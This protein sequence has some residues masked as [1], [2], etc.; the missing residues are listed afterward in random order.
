M[1][2]LFLLS[3]FILSYSGDANAA[4]QCKGTIWNDCHGIKVLSNGDKY[5][6]SFKDNKYNGKGTYTSASGE[7]YIGS[8]KRG[9]RH[10]YGTY[11]YNDGSVYVGDFV[12]GKPHGKGNYSWKNGDTFEGEYKWG[13]RNGFG[14]FTKNSRFLSLI[15]LKS[16][17]GVWIDDKFKL[18]LKE[19]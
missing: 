3:I 17:K 12:D 13:L 11:S 10:G 1:I 16:K 4:V 2:R 15:G 14:V 7:V 9:Q 5:V 6:G 18:F 19:E 8:F